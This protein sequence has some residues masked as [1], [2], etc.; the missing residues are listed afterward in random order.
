[1]IV[2]GRKM[3]DTDV[4]RCERS[5]IS[6]NPFPDRPRALQAYMCD[7]RRRAANLLTGTLSWRKLQA[8]FAQIGNLARHDWIRASGIVKHAVCQLLIKVDQASSNELTHLLA[9]CDCCLQR[10]REDPGHSAH[11]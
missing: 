10:G 7:Q 3:T 6:V 9:P 1:M 8:V 2:A 4:R 5:L 11:V